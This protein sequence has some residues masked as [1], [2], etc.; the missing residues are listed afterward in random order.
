MTDDSGHHSDKHEAEEK[1]ETR[2]VALERRVTQRWALRV[3]WAFT[4]LAVSFSIAVYVDQRRTDHN[5][6]KIAAN[7]IKILAL[8]QGLHS[9]ALGECQ[10]VNILRARV[11]ANTIVIHTALTILAQHL[12]ADLY[13]GDQTQMRRES[14]KQLRILTKSLRIIPPTDCKAA[15]E[16]PLTYEPPMPVPVP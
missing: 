10:R 8:Q 7:N 6:A 14:L 16:H 3:A 15:V 2:I 9:A 5:T 13:I 11:N 4:L 1:H 12:A